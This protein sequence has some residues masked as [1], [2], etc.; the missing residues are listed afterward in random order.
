MGKRT[1]SPTPGSWL[2]WAVQRTAWRT[3]LQPERKG[4]REVAQ[5]AAASS[6]SSSRPTSRS[7]NVQ[8]GKH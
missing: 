7:W 6:R 1:L 4:G 8:S 2:C 3:S 5:P